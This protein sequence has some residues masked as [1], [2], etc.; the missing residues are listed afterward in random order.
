MQG[1]RH[2]NPNLFMN[3]DIKANQEPVDLKFLSIQ[4]QSIPKQLHEMG[5]VLGNRTVT[6]SQGVELIEMTLNEFLL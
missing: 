6:L 1:L 5:L 2:H 3:A 4:V